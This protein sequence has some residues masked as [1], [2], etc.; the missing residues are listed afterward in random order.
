MSIIKRVLIILLVGLGA[1]G[2]DQS[3]KHWASN[4][5]Q[6][7]GTTSYLGDSVRIGYTEN[8]GAFLGLGKDLP[9]HVRYLIFTVLVGVFLAAFLIYMLFSK[10]ISLYPLIG[11]ALIFSGGVS[12]HF[13]RATNNGAV[14]D[15]LNLGIGP[16]RTGVFNIADVAIMLGALIFFLA[17]FRS[18]EE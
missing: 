18:V 2:C 9:E 1:I 14:V 3:S 8:K 7:T 15:F 6:N 4:H 13:D 10:S 16:L 12:N 5:L 17:S 11:F